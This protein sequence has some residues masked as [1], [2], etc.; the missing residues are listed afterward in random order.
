MLAPT[1]YDPAAAAPVWERFLERVLPDAGVCAWVQRYMG[2][3]L[4][5]DV[6]EQVLA[7]AYGTGA[8]GKSV[9]LDVM[10]GVVGDYGLR[11]A[12]ELVLVKLGEGG[13]VRRG[14]QGEDQP[15]RGQAHRPTD[16]DHRRRLARARY[17]RGTACNVY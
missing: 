2:Y 6:R 7:F 8:N 9:L 1:I 11:A 4:T 12:A 3:A 5:G 15:P 17:R 13:A 16:G 14:E 10:L